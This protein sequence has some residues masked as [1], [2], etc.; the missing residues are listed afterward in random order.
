MKRIVWP[1]LVIFALNVPIISSLTLLAGCGVDEETLNEKV[2]AAGF[3][4]VHPQGYVFFGCGN[5]D[6]FHEEF[7]AVNAQGHRIKGV[8]CCGWLKNCTVR[9]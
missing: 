8:L 1:A 6:T 2:R 4:D 7:T 3:T 9:F 5:N